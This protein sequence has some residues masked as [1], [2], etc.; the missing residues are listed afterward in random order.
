[1]AADADP[2][3]AVRSAFPAAL[4]FMVTRAKP[5]ARNM[6][7]AWPTAPHHSVQR[8]PMRSSV[9]THTR[10]ASCK[11][12]VPFFPIVMGQYH[13]AEVVQSADPLALD[14]AVAGKAE[15]GRCICHMLDGSL[16][17]RHESIQ[18]VTPAIPTHSCIICNQ[19]A[20]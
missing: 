17:R 19:I 14:W 11:Q 10:V 8:R 15:Y 18:T 5:P 7:M 2:N 4:A 6:A 3:E 12:L 13:I 9:K 1:M 20:S 16:P